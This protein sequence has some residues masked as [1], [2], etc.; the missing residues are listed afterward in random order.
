MRADWCRQTP[1]KP[2]TRVPPFAAQKTKEKRKRE[3][4]GSHRF[5]IATRTTTAVTCA[6]H[7]PRVYFS[8]LMIPVPLSWQ[9][10]I[11]SLGMFSS[12]HTRIGILGK[13]FC[14]NYPVAISLPYVYENYRTRAHASLLRAL[15]RVLLEIFA[16]RLKNL[17]FSFEI[18]ALIL[19]RHR[20]RY[21]F[22]SP[23]FFPPSRHRN[24]SVCTYANF[25]VR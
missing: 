8:S 19:D 21:R 18:T 2:F 20:R 4:G 16:S 14:M 17:L 7:G 10:Y 25:P 5:A 11:P 13:L 1:C 24:H 9:V 15:L 23:P 22:P 3:R 12:P 6:R